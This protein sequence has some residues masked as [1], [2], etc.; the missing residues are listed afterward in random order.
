MK[1][2]DQVLLSIILKDLTVTKFQIVSH[3][4]LP[5]DRLARTKCPSQRRCLQAVR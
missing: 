5:E 3:A 1:I 4:V 2:I